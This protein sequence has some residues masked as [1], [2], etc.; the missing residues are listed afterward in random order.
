MGAYLAW[1]LM[2]FA[3]PMA[4]K[5]WVEKKAGAIM[6]NES[7]NL[8]KM[9]NRAGF[10]RSNQNLFKRMQNMKVSDIR[11]SVQEIMDRYLD[12]IIPLNNGFENRLSRRVDTL[13]TSYENGSVFIPPAFFYHISR[14]IPGAGYNGY[15]KF[16]THIMAIKQKFFLF[17]FENRYNKVDQTVTPFIRSVPGN[18][19]GP[20]E[21]IFKTGGMLPGKFRTGVIVTL[22][23][24]IFLAACGFVILAGRLKKYTGS[25]LQPADELDLDMNELDIGKAYFF[26]SNIEGQ[27]L[28]F[29]RYL[30]KRNAVVIGK[31][32]SSLY[33]AGTT[34]GAWLRYITAC[35]GL[36]YVVIRQHLKHLEIS[37]NHLKQ[38]IKNLDNEFFAG[39]F[40]AVSMA[41]YA[42]I[43]VFDNFLDRVSKRFE[44][45]VKQAMNHF[46]PH[47]VLVYVSSSMYDLTVKEH[48]S[49]NKNISRLVAVDPEAVIL[50]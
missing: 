44:K 6:S 50:R 3:I 41:R 15:R 26:H 17:Y 40:L 46:A 23:Y 48:Q 10:E 29:I 34:L 24:S 38:K 7:V 19:N 39:A 36:D 5:M 21:N 27:N 45:N 9:S 14:E 42:P 16:L 25:R 47:A 43:Y 13:V 22:A 12:N 4:T 32:E 31:P 37:G 8:Q 49:Q 2:V 30:E 20:H 35:S 11:A 18:K 1:F 28:R 33:D